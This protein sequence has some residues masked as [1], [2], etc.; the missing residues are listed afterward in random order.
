MCSYSYVRSISYW[1]VLGAPAQTQSAL[2]TGGKR[3]YPVS[4]SICNIVSSILSTVT[5]HT[6]VILH[7]SHKVVYSHSHIYKHVHLANLP[8]VDTLL[9]VTFKKEIVGKSDNLQKKF[10]IFSI[11]LVPSVYFSG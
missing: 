8:Y 9:Q 11:V 6:Y 2:P 4:H 10:Q 5:V 1:L 3:V 7:C